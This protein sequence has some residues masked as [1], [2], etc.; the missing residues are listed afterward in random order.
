VNVREAVE[1]FRRAAIEKGDL[2]V[3]AARDHALHDEMAQAWR[4]LES[5]G[6]VGRDAFKSLLMDDSPHVRVWAAA[7]LLA[8]GD[9]SAV[10]VL[11]AEVESGGIRGF[12]SEI[13]LHEWRRGRLEPPFGAVDA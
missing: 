10:R 11:E 4:S 9:E 6:A 13:T 7:Q 8:L 1:R 12:E 2:A 5:I 3:S